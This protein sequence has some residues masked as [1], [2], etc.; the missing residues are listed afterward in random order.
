ML[1]V[2]L[3]RALAVFL[4][5]TTFCAAEQPRKATGPEA[6]AA[7]AKWLDGIKDKGLVLN[8]QPAKQGFGVSYGPSAFGNVTKFNYEQPGW[9]FHLTFR[10]DIKADTPLKELKEHLWHAVI[11]KV[12]T[13]GLDVPGWDIKPQT[14][15]S[16]FDQGIEILSYGEGKIKVRVLTNFFAIYGRDPSVQVP[17]DAPS[18]PGSYFQLRKDFPLDL[19]IEAPVEFPK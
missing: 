18:P 7:A 11:D 15:V 12:P 5:S 10:G 13:P 14:P 1:R 3:V 9:A 4:L 6:E 17:A 8:E 16:S 2:S 19:T